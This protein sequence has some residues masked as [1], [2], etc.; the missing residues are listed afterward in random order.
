M[1]QFKF[2]IAPCCSSLLARFLSDFLP[3]SGR[4]SFFRSSFVSG[5]RCHQIMLWLADSLLPQRGYARGQ[6]KTLGRA[7]MVANSMVVE[8]RHLQLVRVPTGGLPKADSSTTELYWKLRG[9]IAMNSSGDWKSFGKSLGWSTNLNDISAMSFHGSPTSSAAS[10][11]ATASSAG[12]SH[13]IMMIQPSGSAPE[14]VANLQVSA[15]AN[16]IRASQRQA[17][18]TTQGRL[19]LPYLNSV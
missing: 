13:R 5:P 1:L 3:S 2:L 15:P 18:S 9:F 12:S 16:T 6:G 10:G 19:W 8:I 14:G 11:T 17:S 4:V 7:T